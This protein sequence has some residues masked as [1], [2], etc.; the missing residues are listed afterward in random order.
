MDAITEQHRHSQSKPDTVKKDKAKS[1]GPQYVDKTLGCRYELKYLISESE[2]VAITEF[3][4]VHMP[5]DRYSKLQPGGYYPIV[6]LYLDSED[7]TLCRESLSGKKN[8][9]KLRIRSYSDDEQYPTFFEIKRRISSVIMKSRAPA[10]HQDVP[11][12]LKGLMLP[13]QDFRT[14]L[15][16]LNQFQLYCS[17]LTAQPAILIRYMRKAYESES[18]NRVRVTF[19]RELC[20]KVTKEPRVT[21]NGPGWQTNL[22]TV[23]GVILEIKFTARYPIW[24]SRLVT[25]FNLNSRSISKFATSMQQSSMLGYC[26]P[27]LGR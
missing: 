14:N 6:S 5:E 18:E 24:L 16:A 10:R 17:Y 20:Y 21:L 11:M 22:L 27:W 26:G 8:R 9:F 4:K 13:Q 15:E 1:K 25:T 19:D 2:A 12:L 7:L 23:K 3:I